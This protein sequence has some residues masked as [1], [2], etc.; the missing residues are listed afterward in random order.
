MTNET[1]VRAVWD[2]SQYCK[3]AGVHEAEEERLIA[4]LGRF[5]TSHELQ[6]NINRAHVA[7]AQNFFK[8]IA[9]LRAY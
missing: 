1:S 6:M 7:R 4:M 2:I 3:K 9:W 8:S 5:A